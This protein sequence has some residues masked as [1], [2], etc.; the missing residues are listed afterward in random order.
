MAPAP[1]NAERSELEATPF[2]E[3][4]WRDAAGVIELSGEP[5]YKTPERLWARPTLDIHGLAAG[6]AGGGSKTIIP[7][8]ASAKFSCRLV[9]DQE[10]HEIQQLVEDYLMRHGPP[11]VR[12]TV[13]L[14]WG[15]APA[16]TTIDHP[17]LRAGGRA[18]EAAFG[19]A[20]IFQR[21]GGS[22][23]SVVSFADELGLRS[24]LLGFGVPNGNAHGPNEW[25]SLVNYRGGLETVARLWSEL[26]R[27]PIEEAR[28]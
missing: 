11:A 21:S 25:L 12:V 14:L 8:S 17:V 28:S 19:M 9:P 10:Y 27:M 24:M 23:G 20:P 5:E 3:E 26:R 15:A 7:A 1:T 16:I 22:I 13:R 4:A 2:D 6:Y 18:L